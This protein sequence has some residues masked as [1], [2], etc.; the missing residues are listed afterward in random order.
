MKVHKGS[1]Q[2][3][4]RIACGRES[5]SSG[6]AET[7]AATAS[8]LSA[9]SV[10]TRAAGKT[11]ASS[12]NLTAPRALASA[13]TVGTIRWSALVI[14]KSTLLET[15]LIRSEEHTSELQS[16]MRLSYAVICSKKKNTKYTTQ[17]TF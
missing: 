5:R 15:R 9:T 17:S 7:R 14:D 8:A 4:R 1:A 16:L 13:W 12:A 11:E 2:T 3:N 10:A 6:A